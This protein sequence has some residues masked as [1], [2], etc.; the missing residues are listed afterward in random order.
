MFCVR[1]VSVC[2]YC[3]AVAFNSGI[4]YQI[5][6]LFCVQDPY[7]NFTWKPKRNVFLI[8]CAPKQKFCFGL[9]TWLIV[10]KIIPLLRMNPNLKI[11]QRYTF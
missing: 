9:C 5:L 1:A 6:K 2:P 10:I 11:E 8:V 7:L 3:Y 4:S